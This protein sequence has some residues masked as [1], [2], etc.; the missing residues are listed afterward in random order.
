MKSNNIDNTAMCEIC[1]TKLEIEIK[2]KPKNKID[3][4]SKLWAQDRDQ[5]IKNKFIYYKPC[6]NCYKFYTDY[7]RHRNGCCEYDCCECSIT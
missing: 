3:I 4:H 7:N 6:Y 5:K 1:G 2:S